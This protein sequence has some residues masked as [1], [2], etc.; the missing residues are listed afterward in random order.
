MIPT[1]D[2]KLAKL[3]SLEI[4]K[5][6]DTQLPYNEQL[7]KTLYNKLVNLKE[8]YFRRINYRSL[9][10]DKFITWSELVST[11]KVFQI[12]EFKYEDKLNCAMQAQKRK[13]PIKIQF[14]KYFTNPKPDLD[15]SFKEWVKISMKAKYL[16]FY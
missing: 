4:L 14:I 2:T 5:F 6:Q 7:E 8:L 3:I 16:P 10:I 15:A 12:F 9:K 13:K 1:D 11:I